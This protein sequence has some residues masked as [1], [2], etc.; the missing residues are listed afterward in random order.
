VYGRREN[1][2]YPPLLLYHLG[3]PLNW[4]EIKPVAVV[5][6]RKPSREGEEL[7]RG[8]VRELVKRG[9]TIVTGL[10]EGVDMAATEEALSAGGRVIGV[11]PYMVESRDNHTLYLLSKR[12]NIAEG[13]LRS[14][15][16][17]S[18][19]LYKGYVDRQL[20]LRNRITAGSSI[21]VIIPETRYKR[22]RWGTKHQV[23]YGLKAERRVIIFKPR[24]N[25]KEVVKGFEYFKNAH[26]ERRADI[27]ESIDDMLSI[28]K[29]AEEELTNKLRS[30]LGKP[31]S[32]K[33]T[34]FL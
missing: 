31:R 22:E 25:D 8:I 28:L 24:V 15:A 16:V 18:E 6:T 20:V 4:D 33:I 19:N 23:Q 21:A 12:G 7:T 9:Y 26:A 1:K 11:I 2:V 30:K 3:Q 27:V 32:G 17:I 13:L 29:K 10:A 5:G 14:G 34:D